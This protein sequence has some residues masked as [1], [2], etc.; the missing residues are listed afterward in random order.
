VTEQVRAKARI[1]EE[2]RRRD[3]FLAMLSHELR[4]PL[5]AMVTATAMLKNAASESS[6]RA[7][8]VSVL[9]RQSRQMARLLD[10]LLEVSR[11]TQNKIELRRR[12]VDLRLIAGEAADAVRSQME[13]KGLTFTVDLD[14]EPLWVHG[15][16]ARLQQVQINLLSNAAKYTDRGGEVS[17]RV[18]QEANGAVI[19]VKDN[20]NGISPQM[21]DSV[22]D[23]FV[24]GPHTL[25]HS[26]GGLGVGLT[27]V[28]ALVEMHGGTVTAH[29][30]G[31]GAG[32][33]FSVR[34]PL[35]TLTEPAFPQ[36][37]PTLSAARLS[38]PLSAT[39]V[40]IVEDNED[41]REMLCAMLTHAGLVCH[42][43]ADGVT[44]LQLID[45]VSPAVVL[46]DVGLPGIDGLEVAR[47]IRANPRHA[48]V[49]LI[50]LTGYGQTADRVATA[51]A[52]FDHHLVKPVDP[53]ELLALLA[54]PQPSSASRDSK[55]RPQSAFIE[56]AA[57]P[58]ATGQA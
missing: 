44:G 19:R 18:R 8:T 6:M 12:V 23:L 10:D 14:P 4:N 53:S 29:S 22:F 36:D 37:G 41:S 26:N 21:L 38:V 2:V 1:D 47:R 40:V 9:E 55:A 49:R 42:D 45:D 33:E 50:A 32:S 39:T 46:L 20:G 27:L 28:R 57:P 52:G 58:S 34:L 31:E 48:G 17:L 15:D 51:Q 13:D 56:E 35:T 25:D 5:G 30:D 16:S 54:Q 3:Q 24:Q 43:A 11:V 7:R